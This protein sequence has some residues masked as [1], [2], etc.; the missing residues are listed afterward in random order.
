MSTSILLKEMRSMREEMKGLQKKTRE[1]VRDVRDGMGE[2]ME[3]V[4]EE[5]ISVKDELRESRKE[6]AALKKRKLRYIT[7][8]KFRSNAELKAAVMLWCSDRNKAIA[9]YGHIK[10]WNVSSITSMRLLFGTTITERDQGNRL[11]KDFNEDLSLWYT[12]SV[13]NMGCLFYGAES[14]TGNLSRWDV[15]NCTAMSAMFQD[16]KSF[17]SDLKEWN[18]G[19]VTDMSRMFIRASSFKSDLTK[20]STGKVTNMFNMLIL[21]SSFNKRTIRNWDLSSIKAS[22]VTLRGQEPKDCTR[23]QCIL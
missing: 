18:V 7:Q 9:Q 15:G 1:E 10:G 17:K 23:E 20:W 3:S 12:S 19:K 4:F 21:A 22:T 2:K 16:A 13:T 8:Y 11:N 6:I 5:K 14:F